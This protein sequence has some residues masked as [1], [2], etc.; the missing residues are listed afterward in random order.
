MAGQWVE[1][2]AGDWAASMV[3]LV[4]ASMA[5]SMAHETDD[6]KVDSKGKMKGRYWVA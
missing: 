3:E 6:W 1:S 5:A 4:V 2:M